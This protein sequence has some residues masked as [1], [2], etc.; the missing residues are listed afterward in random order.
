MKSEVG[1]VGLGVIGQ[2][3]VPKGVPARSW[4]RSIE[5]CWPLETLGETAYGKRLFGK[6]VAEARFELATFGLREL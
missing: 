1:F 2:P 4:H 5:R 6:L 3:M